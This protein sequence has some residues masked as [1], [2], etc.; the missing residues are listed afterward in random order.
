MAMGLAPAVTAYGVKDAVGCS[1]WCARFNIHSV[2]TVTKQLISHSYPT[3]G[4]IESCPPAGRSGSSRGPARRRWWCHRR[5]RRWCG[6]QPASVG[7]RESRDGAARPHVRRGATPQAH[8]M[9]SW[10]AGGS[11]PSDVG[12]KPTD[13]GAAA[14]TGFDGACRWCVTKGEAWHAVGS[15][16]DIPALLQLHRSCSEC[17]EAAACGER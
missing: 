2:V 10:V 13:L 4:W 11:A 6:Q 9:C 16:S 17:I 14:S 3:K 8:C 7:S 1:T 5:R 12:R 15:P